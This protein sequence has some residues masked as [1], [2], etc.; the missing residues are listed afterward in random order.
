MAFESNTAS[1]YS[2]KI[3][4]GLAS[5]NVIAV[6]PTLV[7]ASNLKLPIKEEQNYLTTDSESNK[8]RLRVDFWLKSTEVNPNIVTKV[9][10]FLEN[11]NSESKLTPGLFQFINEKGETVWATSIEEASSKYEWFKGEKIRKSFVGE[12][13]LI[14]FIKSWLS[15]GRNNIAE[16][17][18]PKALFQGNV[19]ELKSLVANNNEAKV[20][21]LLTVREYEGNYYQ[22]VYNRYFA[23]GS[24]TSTKYWKLHLDKSSANINYQNS[25]KLQ[26]FNPLEVTEDSSPQISEESIFNV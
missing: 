6:N 14:G 11:V 2:E 20:Q 3:Y 22:N 8:T 17:D 23:R 19:N 12:A 26:E 1:N 24:N 5:M 21:V 9:T 25:F 18:N 16:L 10:F 4:T 15:I 7:E 13:D